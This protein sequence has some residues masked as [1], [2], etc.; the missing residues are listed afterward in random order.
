[1]TDNSQ[2]QTPASAGSVPQPRLPN[3]R[4]GLVLFRQMLLY[5]FALA[6]LLVGC[7]SFIPGFMNLLPI[8]GVTELVQSGD[9]TVTRLEDVPAKADDIEIVNTVIR[10]TSELDRLGYA[11]QLAIVLVGVWLLMLPVSWVH[12]G[13]HRRST[14]DHSLDETTLILPG[15]VAAI[16]LVVQHSL[17]L[18]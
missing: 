2:A 3:R 9:L 7:V 6:L 16:V 4:D 8:G 17:A 1:M 13:I 11:R 18:A 5:H 12:K 14:Y 15:V 10:A